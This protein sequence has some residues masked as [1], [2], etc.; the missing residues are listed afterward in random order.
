MEDPVRRELALTM[1]RLQ[2]SHKEVAAAFDITVST[3][4]K[5]EK[6][7]P[8]WREAIQQAMGNAFAPVL[9]H[10]MDLALQANAEG[11]NEGASKALDLVM[12]WYTKQ[13]DREHSSEQV[14]KRIEADRAMPTGNNRGILSTPEAA[15][16]F[17][18]ELA[19][20]PP[21]EAESWE[22]GD[23]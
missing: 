3:L 17:A 14:D 5:E 8:D 9:A 11:T 12:K 23:Q 13:L 18:R 22:E 7:D 20:G 10:A 4:R 15:I 19:A 2:H 16:A 1:Y 21:I 6:V